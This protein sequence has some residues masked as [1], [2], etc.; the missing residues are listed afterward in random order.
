MKNPREILQTLYTERYLRPQKSSRYRKKLLPFPLSRIQKANRKKT[1]QEEASGKGRRQSSSTKWRSRSSTCH[2]PAANQRNPNS[3]K[4][5]E[6]LC[7]NF[8]R[9]CSIGEFR[10][11]LETTLC[12]PTYCRCKVPCI[13]FMSDAL[14]R[15]TWKTVEAGREVMSVPWSEMARSW[16][17]QMAKKYR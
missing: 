7:P 17:S 4:E 2:H 8:G 6:A 5:R 16:L 3:L 11:L 1:T 14:S 9:L 13:V 15:L 10:I 12:H